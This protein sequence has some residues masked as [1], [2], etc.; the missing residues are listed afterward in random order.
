MRR[1]KPTWNT[2]MI[3]EKMTLA[4]RIK[5]VR[6]F[7]SQEA[8]AA[9]IGLSRATLS[10]YER[11]VS[12]PNAK[13]LRKICNI[14]KISPEWLL[15]GEGNMFGSNTDTIEPDKE[16]IVLPQSMQEHL[17][18]AES[19]FR[20]RLRIQI[21]FSERERDALLRS[22]DAKDE[23]I[24]EMRE[25]IALYRELLQS[26][27]TLPSP[28]KLQEPRSPEKSRNYPRPEAGTWTEHGQMSASSSN[29]REK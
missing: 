8:F 2:G 15:V 6:G 14:S 20:E 7:E 3:K 23:T 11:G 18:I 21:A 24:R 13:I 10:L 22:L 19:Q 17:D 28:A 12:E 26:G 9:K 29:E 16:P 5:A 27:R 4:E 1:G 25:Q